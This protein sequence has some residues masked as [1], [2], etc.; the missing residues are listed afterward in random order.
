[1]RGM[2]ICM[3]RGM[4]EQEWEEKGAE[5]KRDIERERENQWVRKKTSEMIVKISGFDKCTWD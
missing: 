1:M 2:T 3:K 4:S 5:G